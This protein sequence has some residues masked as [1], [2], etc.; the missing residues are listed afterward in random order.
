MPELSGKRKAESLIGVQTILNP[1]SRPTEN[2]S[3]DQSNPS[4]DSDSK[5]SLQ[6]S[7]SLSSQVKWN[8]STS[9]DTKPLEKK[10]KPTMV[11]I[12]CLNLETDISEINGIYS[13]KELDIFIFCESNR[14]FINEKEL[15][16]IK[17][18]KNFVVKC[19][20][21]EPNN[22]EVNS[23]SKF[24]VIDLTDSFNSTKIKTIPVAVS[25][26]TLTTHTIV[27]KLHDACFKMSDLYYPMS[28]PS[29]P[30]PLLYVTVL[31]KDY[32]IKALVDCGASRTF[33]GPLCLEMIKELNFPIIER[34][35]SVQ[36]ANGE[37]LTV[38]KEVTLPVELNGRTKP[39]RVPVLDSLTEPL[40]LGLDFLKYYKIQA[41][42]V[43]RTWTY[44]NKPKKVYNF[45]SSRVAPESCAGLMELDATQRDR[46]EHFLKEQLPEIPDKPGL[47]NL[48]EHVIDVGDSTPVKQ[49]CYIVSPKVLEATVTELEQMLADDVIEP[50]DSDWSNPIVM[51]KKPN[52]EYRFCLDFRKLNFL[53]KKDAYPLPQM[54]S[55]LTKLRKARYISKIDLH[56]GFWQIPLSKE[57]R[58]KTAF[59]IPGRGLFQ[60]KRMPFGL[61]NAPATFQ[62]LVDRLIGPEM[63]PYC[64]AYLDDIIIVTETF[65]EHLKWLAVV[66]G[67][68]K[69]A[70]LKIN[71]NKCEFVV[72]Q[73]RYLGFMVNEKGLLVDPDK[74]AP[75][76]N[77]PPPS[78]VKE[79]RRFLGMASWYRRFIP[80]YA[81]ISSPLNKLLCKK[82]R[83]Y[84]TEPQ[85]LAFEEI[86]KTLADAP[87]LSRPDFDHPFEL[88]TDASDVGLG[89]VLS[90]RINGVEYVICYASRSLSAAERQYSTTEKECLAVIWSIQKFRAY[91]E[92]YHFTVITDH[93]S[94][95]W[96]HNLKNPTGRLARWSLSLLEYDFEILHRKGAMHHVPDA[97]SRIS[98]TVTDVTT[99]DPEEILYEVSETDQSWYT[100]RF[101]LVTEFPGRFPNWRIADGKLYYHRPD[102]IISTVTEDL[103]AWKLVPSEKDR[104]EILK[105]AHDEPQAGH[106]GTQK[107]Y[108]RIAT[109]Y[110]W[111]GCYREVAKFVR[112]CQTCQ[113][114]KVDQSVPAGLMGQRIVEQPWTVIATDIMGPF[115]P[116][117]ASFKY[118][119]VIQDI[120]TK[121]IEIKAL[122]NA[123]GKL[124][125]ES[126]RELIINRWGTPLV[127]L[128]DNGTEFVNNII[129][130]FTEEFGIYHSTTPPYH[131]Q[132]NPV[133]R[134]N[135]VLKTMIVSF[136]DQDHRNWDKN[137]GEFRFAYN[138]AHHD[139]LKTTPAFLN[140]GRHPKAIN[141]LRNKTSNHP[142]INPQN[143]QVW[144][145]RMKKLQIMN[146]WVIENLD[147]AYVKQSQYYN[148][149]HRPIKY[150]VGD[151]V[152]TRCRTLSSKMKNVTS[153][154]NPR[155]V[156]PYKI[157]EILS[158]CVVQ[159][160]D[161]SLVEL[162][163]VHVKDIKPFLNTNSNSDFVDSE[164]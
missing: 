62:R 58:A 53:T 89:A 88:Q 132:S 79:L 145:D 57:S 40:V 29:S 47:T 116:S 87:V 140:L 128:T 28:A 135:R 15:N 52:G 1:S 13:P 122:R 10:V 66:L 81:T 151:L 39:L 50:S 149:H 131:P 97:L 144:E 84:W 98:L 42:F 60:F 31:I 113:S 95:R 137:L 130:S 18:N 75:I 20:P 120:F 86:R 83:W 125:T 99:N 127:L 153:K 100:R 119:L 43:T 61:T 121:W 38:S 114:C 68:L 107:T 36:L 139:T 73:V 118:I 11:E 147:K 77:Y 65:E 54:D 55:I 104:D 133:E 34:V 123:T 67:R 160:C 74:V 63:D 96:L 24:E 44:K 90:Q 70:G 19:K 32:A 76:Q 93:S 9:L 59:A 134:V 138:T 33:I 72:P 51:V 124:V 112:Y 143:P 161:L 16:K 141:E 3:P 136:I 146:D 148:K 4:F 157:V 102:P 154:L 110:Y 150:N 78:S 69:N 152:L 14:Y 6:N 56:K 8:S 30:E 35:G 2:V 91:L 80:H 64:F 108:M 71:P 48:T 5:I 12:E 163:K 101:L 27:E 126:L 117:R 45:E 82:Q 142:Q 111:P 164:E 92:G 129:R 85:Q 103:N 41:D 109:N 49:R 158:P 106:L 156:G 25:E 22:Q 26:S 159:L 21:T 17:D 115:P 94:L 46:L 162:G 155:Y 23:H 105:E 37:L 7:N